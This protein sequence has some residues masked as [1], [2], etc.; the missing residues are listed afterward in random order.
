M[1]S[2]KFTKATLTK[3]DKVRLDSVKRK[4]TIKAE[5]RAVSEADVLHWLLSLGEQELERKEKG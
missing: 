5:G 3:E 1:T 2:D 4:L